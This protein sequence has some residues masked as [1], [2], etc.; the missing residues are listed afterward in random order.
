MRT[1]NNWRNLSKT[2]ELY[3]RQFPGYDTYYDIVIQYAKGIG[4][5]SVLL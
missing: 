2:G 5:L 1:H 4:D 3:H